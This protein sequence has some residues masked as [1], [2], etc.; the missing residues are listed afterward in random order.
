MSGARVLALALAFALV[1]IGA[2]LSCLDVTPIVVPPRDAGLLAEASCTTCLELPNDQHGCKDTL[3]RC[4]ADPRCA[5]VL[6]CVELASCFDRPILD[7]KLNCGLPCAQEA[8][9]TTT[10]DPT[11]AY[12]LDVLQCGKQEC[13][14]ACNLSDGGVEVDGL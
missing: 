10:N 4:R 7:D 12:L 5:P 11:I 3:D 8:G 9:I 2:L 13:G 14:L 6:A 1:S